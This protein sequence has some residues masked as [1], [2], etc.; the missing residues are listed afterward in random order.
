M[1]HATL[2]LKGVNEVETPVLNE[3]GISACNLIRYQPDNG[4]VLVQKIGGWQKFL[5][6]QTIAPVRALWAWEDTQ[7]F[8]HLGAGTQNQLNTYQTQLSVIT[9][10]APTDITPRSKTD[11]I[12]PVVTSVMGNSI[13]TITD[14][15]ITNVTNYDAVYIPAH[16]SI[17]GLVL[18]GLYPTDPD[19]HVGATTYTIRALDKLGNPLPAPAGSAVPT[20]PIFT[21]TN[22]SPNV[23]V[24]LV[25]HGYAAGD[26]Y[27]CLTITI[28]GGI[29]F[30]GNYPILSI[31]DADNFVITGTTSASATTTGTVNNGK[32]RYVYSFGVG[33]IPAGT[34]YGIGGYGRGGYGSGTAVTPATGDPISAIDWTLDNWGEL[35]IACPI[36]T[37]IILTTTSASGTGATG[38]LNFSQTYT[39]DIGE[40]I[41]VSGVSPSSWNGTYIVTGST[42]SSVSFATAVTAAQT[43]AGTITVETTAFQPIYQ[44]NPEA[45][46]PTA[47]VIA[48]APPVNDGVFVAMPQ[49]QII[50]WGSTFTGV[51]DPLLVRWCDVNNFS[52][53]SSWIGLPT[54]Q[55][56][57]F[58]IPKG[59]RIVGGI[60]GPQ[61]G[62]LWTDIGVWAMQYINQPFI[63]SF[64][65]IGS[66]CGLIGRKAAA[67]FNGSVYWMGPSQFFLM[68]EDG[69]TP[70]P[71]PVW[72][73][74]FQNLDQSNLNKIRIAVNSRFGEIAWYYPTLVSG[75][76]VAAYVKYNVLLQM[77][78]FGALARSAWI[79]Q[80]VLGPPIGADPNLLYIYQH[81]MSPDAD[82][83]AMTPSFRTGYA[84]L[85]DGDMMTFVDQVWPDMKF[86]YYGGMQNATLMLTFY[87]ANYPGD[88][89][90][91]FGPFSFTQATQFLS[92]RIRT[93]LLALE[94][95]SNDVG[96]WWRVGGLRYRYAADGKF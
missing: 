9:D 26:T 92:P 56:G 94:L 23:T 49:R 17:G 80:S 33:A 90:R 62:I 2:R 36:T 85:A 3:M 20:L 91:T 59:S 73:V 19:G 7:A 48:Q 61:Q 21:T 18:F 77:W 43:V 66:G 82:G 42:S 54:N 57:S 55:A 24:T 60:Q 4:A 65:E 51:P 35:L 31:T 22:T 10:G 27:P 45:G 39:A 58:R 14:A 12:A 68:G 28:V 87:A 63:Y 6:N 15:T 88:T 47:T 95:S 83:Q 11:N 41:V 71:C 67:A 30:F 78:D 70:L 89:P 32:A 44:W 13:V 40:V 52:S 79:D 75:G 37:P 16:I 46:A 81:E 86:G 69:V 5:G 96:S 64:N 50:A 34:G 29:T 84:A 76:E 72:D 53:N 25:G 38:T 8:A 74:I 1:P 93:R